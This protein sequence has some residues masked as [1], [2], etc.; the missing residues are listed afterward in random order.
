MKSRLKKVNP[1]F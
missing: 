1:G